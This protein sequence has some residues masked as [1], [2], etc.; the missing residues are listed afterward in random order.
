[1]LVPLSLQPLVLN[2]ASYVV[3][4]AGFVSPAPLIL[5]FL[6]MVLLPLFRYCYCCEC[7]SYHCY[8]FR[9]TYPLHPHDIPIAILTIVAILIPTRNSFTI[10]TSF[11]SI[12]LAMLFV[13]CCFSLSRLHCMHATIHG[14]IVYT[15]C[16]MLCCMHYTL[17]DIS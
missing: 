17:K 5:R 8:G 10:P 14:T 3:L 11:T 16:C 6:L 13:L 12:T 15:I 9:Y 4:L 7:H 1:M 2:T